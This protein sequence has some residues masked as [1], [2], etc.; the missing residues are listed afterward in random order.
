MIFRRRQ[1]F[2]F[3]RR[4][5]LGIFAVLAFVF[6]AQKTLAFESDTP[7]TP[8]ASP[9]AQALLTFFSNIYG[10]KII[11]GQQDGW[12]QTN[13]LSFEL[14]Y[15][16]NTTGKLPALLAMDV[17]GY[18]DRSPRRDTNQRVSLEQNHV[19]ICRIRRFHFDQAAG[20]LEVTGPGS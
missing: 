2:D 4:Q 16:T 13:G 19:A 8:N 18:T 7:V 20:N 10:K 1:N 14:D 6:L 15:I 11:S 17:A 12:R 3:L 9:E 5:A